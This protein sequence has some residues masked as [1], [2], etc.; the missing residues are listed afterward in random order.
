VYRDLENYN[1]AEPLYRRALAIMEKALGPEHP[2]V[3]APLKGLADIDLARGDYT[4]AEPLYQRSLIILERVLGANHRDVAKVL[5]KYAQLLH[6][7]GRVDEAVD[8]E[9]RAKVIRAQYE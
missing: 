8:M 6:K 7:T 3:A 5:E 2:S 1:E 9:A 4:R